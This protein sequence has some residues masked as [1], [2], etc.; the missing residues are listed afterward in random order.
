MAKLM[1]EQAIAETGDE[2]WSRDLGGAVGG[3]VIAYA[4]DGEQRVAFAFGMTSPI[5]PTV[6]TTGKIV[7]FGHEP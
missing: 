7:V 4:A 3:G 1:E 6:K 5:W 2:L